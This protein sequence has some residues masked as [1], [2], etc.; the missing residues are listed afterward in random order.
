MGWKTI[1]GR[2]YYY[3]SKRVGGKV[4]TEYFGAGERAEIFAR[5]DEIERQERESDR[6]DRRLERDEDR[7][8]DRALDDLV[9]EARADAA[10]LLRS[11]GYH[12]HK[13]GEWRRRRGNRPHESGRP[14]AGEGGPGT[15]ERAGTAAAVPMDR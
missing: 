8:I 9:A 6:L 14:G 1:H 13:R 3:R 4:R 10:S 7:K 2:R 11:L 12:Q 5:L 15:G